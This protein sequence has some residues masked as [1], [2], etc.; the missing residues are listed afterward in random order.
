MTDTFFEKETISL[1]EM[2]H[3]MTHEERTDLY[4]WYNE[5]RD[6][7][8]LCKLIIFQCMAEFVAPC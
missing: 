5:A 4:H 1:L 3:N 7:K 8:L 2:K 6:G